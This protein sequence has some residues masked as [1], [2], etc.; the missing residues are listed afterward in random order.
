MLG[1]LLLLVFSV[2]AANHGIEHWKFPLIAL[3][4]VIWF[5]AAAVAPNT[6]S[7]MARLTLFLIFTFGLLWFGSLSKNEVLPII[8]LVSSIWL[9]RFS[10]AASAFLLRR[11]VI[12]NHRAYMFFEPVISL[13]DAPVQKQ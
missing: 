10:Y 2:E 11:T 8:Y 12:K 3:G 1:A 5:S 4:L 6:D 13:K 9:W 7:K